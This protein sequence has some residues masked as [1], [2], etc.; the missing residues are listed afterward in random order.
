MGIKLEKTIDIIIAILQQLAKYVCVVYFA[1]EK[2]VHYNLM[3]FI[4]KM[5]LH[6]WIGTIGLFVLGYVVAKIF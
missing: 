4:N 6:C 3:P 1:G 2:Y 5:T